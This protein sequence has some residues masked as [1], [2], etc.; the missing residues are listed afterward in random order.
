[1]ARFIEISVDVLVSDEELIAYIGYAKKLPSKDGKGTFI[2]NR[3]IASD[4]LRKYGIVLPRGGMIIPDIK[5]GEL[6][7]VVNYADSRKRELEEKEK[8]LAREKEQNEFLSGFISVLEEYPE[9]NLGVKKNF[10]RDGSLS[11][12]VIINSSGEEVFPVLESST[13]SRPTANE[14]RRAVEMELEIT[15]FRKR[16]WQR[17]VDVKIKLNELGEKISL[18]GWD[19]YYLFLQ[20][21]GSFSFENQVRFSQGFYYKERGDWNEK[22][23]LELEKDVEQKI[24]TV[25]EALDGFRKRFSKQ[26]L[27]DIPVGYIW[28]WKQGACISVGEEK[29]FFPTKK[30]ARDTLEWVLSQGACFNHHLIL[31][32]GFWRDLAKKEKWDER[33]TLL[34]DLVVRGRNIINSTETRRTHVGANV[35]GWSRTR[36]VTADI[37]I[38]GAEKLRYEE[39][40]LVVR[41]INLRDSEI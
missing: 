4:S 22:D 16:N 3:A 14:F 23:L 19:G 32:S 28:D 35:R 25:K 12:F 27:T 20:E 5:P 26:D 2:G 36:E 15:E 31:P 33:K 41:L 37:L 21:E 24:S 29:V 39:E 8:K 13:R 11:R 18:K 17:L 7:E 30:S 10:L 9:L 40:E 1:M 6:T 34:C 38:L